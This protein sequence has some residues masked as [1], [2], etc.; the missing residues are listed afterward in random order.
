M[1]QE[2]LSCQ[3]LDRDFPKHV[4]PRKLETDGSR[5]TN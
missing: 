5:P 4:Q 2:L 1:S 3:D